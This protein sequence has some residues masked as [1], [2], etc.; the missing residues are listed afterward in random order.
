MPKKIV[1]V[2]GTGT[3]GEP[4]IGL[5]AD[6]REPL[7]ID[8]VTFSKKQA[9]LT[10]RSKVASLIR[11]GAKLCADEGSMKEF[12]K[13]GL[14]PTFKFEEALDRASVI[15]DCTPVGNDNKL[16]HYEKRIGST[17]GFIAQGSE[18]GF[19]KMYA[20]GINDEALSPGKDRFVQVVSCNTHN[21]S[22]LV[23]TIAMA[24]GKEPDGLESARF[25]CI[26]RASD[27]SQDADFVPAHQ[28]NRHREGR[29][30]THHARDA[31]QLFKTVNLDLNLFSSALKTNTQYMHTIWFNLR[32]KNR[33]SKEEVVERLR[34]NDRVA[35]THKN[36]ANA[37]FSFGRDHGHF[38]RI[39]NQTVVVEGTIDVVGEREVVGWC[40]TPQDGNSL[41][42]SVSATEF[43]LNP[44]DYEKRIQCLKTF[45]FSEV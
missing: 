4:L 9:L 12:Q 43:F 22:V 36:S 28:A 1:H 30:G 44:T 17:L 19:G 16:K 29:F 15:L 27:I 45:F 23:K 3:I 35:L 41:L 14:E 24:N 2:V 34:A 13:I 8:E 37:V 5:L 40:F 20:R 33:I 38:G 10:D 21:L 32:L 42:S 31:H 18:F 7:G 26:R 6:L 11:R 39:L 25:V